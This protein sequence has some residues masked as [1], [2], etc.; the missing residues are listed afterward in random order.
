MASPVSALLLL[1]ISPC[2]AAIT[3]PILLSVVY[4]LFS[5]NRRCECQAISI[6]AISSNTGIYNRSC[7]TLVAPPFGQLCL[8]RNTVQLLR[9]MDMYQ[10]GR[11]PHTHPDA[12]R[13]Q[14]HGMVS[15]VSTA[16]Y[17]TTKMSRRTH[18]PCRG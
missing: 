14:N 6:N 3:Y 8:A 9:R 12:S 11:P 2:N 13:S 10:A 18:V 16:V 1:F 7:T 17:V 4:A 5:C 15:Y